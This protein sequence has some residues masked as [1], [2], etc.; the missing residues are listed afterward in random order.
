[1]ESI[2]DTLKPR[3]G[4]I[5][6]GYFTP[7]H[8]FKYAGDLSKIIYRSSWELRFLRYCD[9]TIKITRYAIEPVCI[10]YV[11]PIDKKVHKYNIDFYIEQLMADMTTKKWLIEIKPLRQILPP[12]PPKQQ[13]IKSMQNYISTIKKCVVNMAKFKTADTFAKSSGASFGVIEMNRYTNQF[14]IIPWE[15]IINEIKV[16]NNGT[17]LQTT[18]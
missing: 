2:K 15:S 16:K 14:I 4:A 11:S 12:K 10:P 6:Q 18:V 3:I 7:K 9:E 8:P 1:M 5:K 13:S 17:E